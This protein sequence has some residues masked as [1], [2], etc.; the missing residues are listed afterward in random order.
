LAGVSIDLSEKER[1]NR[2]KWIEWA[3]QLLPLA[4]KRA[5]NC[6]E[7]EKKNV[8]AGLKDAVKKPMEPNK[9]EEAEQPAQIKK[10]RPPSWDTWDAPSPKAKIPE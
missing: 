1:G 5:A 2:E 10:T 3:K 7:D 4:E 8:D 6:L 9:T